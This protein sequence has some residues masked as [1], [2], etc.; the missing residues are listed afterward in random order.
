MTAWGSII[1]E[2]D[3]TLRAFP[4]HHRALNSMMRYRIKHPETEDDYLSADC[5]FKRAVTFNGNDGVVWMLYGMYQHKIGLKKEALEKYQNAEKLLKDFAE[6]E[7]N[8]GL[9][10]FDLGDYESSLKNAKKAY[11]IG[12]PLPGLKQK[13]IKKGK[14][15]N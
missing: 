9:L 14:W 13:L 8:I 11:S 15:K 2:I 10:Y 12:Y 7:Y 5:Y 1:G 6:L 3:Y 4:N